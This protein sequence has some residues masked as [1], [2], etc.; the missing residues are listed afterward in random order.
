MYVKVQGDYQICGNAD[1]SMNTNIPAIT[2]TQ[3]E[4]TD[5]IVGFEYTETSSALTS[6]RLVM[7]TCSVDSFAAFELDIGDVPEPIMI[8]LEDFHNS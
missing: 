1:D 3:I 8:Q 5:P 7:N 4:V 6:L 2:R